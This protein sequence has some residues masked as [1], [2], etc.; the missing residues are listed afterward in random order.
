[1]HSN[2]KVMFDGLTVINTYSFSPVADHCLRI[3]PYL[4]RLKELVSHSPREYG[5]PFQRWTAQWLGKH[6]AK[7]LGIKVIPIS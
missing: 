4:G 7:E 3:K 1:M 2:T 6:L 5:Y